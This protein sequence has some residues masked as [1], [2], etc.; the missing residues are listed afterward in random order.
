MAEEKVMVFNLRQAA[1]KTPK[2]RRSR[3]II[4]IL[5]RGA[6]KFSK[7]GEVK[8]DPKISEK[9]WSRGRKNPQMKL[10]IKLRKLDNGSVETELVG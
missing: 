8:I 7:N 9:I 3:D 10:K 4:S 5:R 1:L 6:A 2:Q